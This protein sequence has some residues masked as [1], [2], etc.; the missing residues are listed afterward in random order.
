MSPSV[1]YGDGD[2]L[3]FPT[4]LPEVLIQSLKVLAAIAEEPSFLPGSVI[5]CH[6]LQGNDSDHVGLLMDIYPN[7]EKV[8]IEPPSAGSG[9]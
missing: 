6:D 8:H 5:L 1:V 3:C 4:S 2:V 9:G 7:V